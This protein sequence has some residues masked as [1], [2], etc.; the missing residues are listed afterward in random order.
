MNKLIILFSVLFL[1]SCNQSSDYMDLF[2]SAKEK[3]NNGD[4]SEAID[5][6]ND[7]IKLKPDFDSAYTERAYNYLQIEKP[8]IALKDVNKAIKINFN[9]ISAYYTRGMIYSYLYKFDKALKDYNHIIR[10]GDSIYMNV[11]LRERAYTYYYS[12]E[13]DKAIKDFSKIIE[14]DS[15][16]YET[17]VSRGIAKLR[18]DVYNNYSDS[19]KTALLDTTLYAKFFEYFKITYTQNGYKNIL[20]DTRGAIEDFSKAIKIK[21]DYSYAYYNRAKVFNDLKL[22]HQALTDINEAIK[23][24]RNS[25]YYV[26]RGLIYKSIKVSEKSL[27][28]F[29]KAIEIN[30]ENGIA[31][32]NRAYLKRE[33][34]NDTKGAKKD[35]KTAEKFGIKY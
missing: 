34:L 28:D 8:K 25:D 16:S 15:L 12:N 11:A 21:P 35:I 13:I 24:T 32:I 9:N 4:Y 14:L 27:N 7:I 20:Y 18:S 17:Y 30:P 1:V 2:H 33:Q 23:L 3:T 29:N 6:L 26:T 31:Y 5:L 10:L 19:I 22:T